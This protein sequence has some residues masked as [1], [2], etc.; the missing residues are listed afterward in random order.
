MNRSLHI[1]FYVQHLLGIGHI[2]RASLL[3]RGWLDAGLSVTVVSGGEP[4]PQFGFDGARLIQLPAVHAADA[5]FSGLLDSDNRPLD[6]RF[7]ERRC[8]LLLQALE[9]A[10]PDV[11]VIENYPFG[12]RQLRWELRPLL[13]A[14]K[15]L[16]SRPRILS[17]VRDILQARK[18]ERIRETLDLLGQ[19]F[20]G[21]LVHGDQAFI[22]LQESFPATDSLAGKLLYTGYVTDVSAISDSSVGKDEVIVSAG[23]GAVGFQLMMTALQ[24]REQTRLK[25]LKWRFLLGPNMSRRERLKLEQLA[26]HSCILEA[27]RPDFPQLL[28]NCRLSVSQAGYN[29][30]MDVLGAGCPA[31]LVPFEGSGETEQITRTRRLEELGICA[32]VTEAELAADSLAMAIH[33]ALNGPGNLRSDHAVTIDLNGAQRSAE[34][35][36][37]LFD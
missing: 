17:S 11:L 6:D 1:L 22:P 24:A 13:Q 12:R 34:L 18:P 29:T 25:G 15:Q 10:Q 26:G 19:Y 27:V 4:V 8:Q 28:A 33:G 32:M 2:K 7:R 21:V 3:V 23:G 5:G 36:Q 31:V 35:I 16:R 20:D 14:A 9:Q 30:V 37:G